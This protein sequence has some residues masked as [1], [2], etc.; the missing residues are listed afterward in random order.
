MYSVCGQNHCGDRDAGCA[1][2]SR[3]INDKKFVRVKYIFNR[4]AP[5]HVYG[6]ANILKSGDE[7]SS[8]SRGLS[9]DLPV[10]LTNVL[11]EKSVI[12]AGFRLTSRRYKS[13]QRIAG[14]VVR[15]ILAS[16]PTK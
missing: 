6:G 9:P 16:I 5:W 12:E 15:A 2:L 7:S 8:R 14:D 13:D 3:I 1:A 10:T 4:Q 11:T